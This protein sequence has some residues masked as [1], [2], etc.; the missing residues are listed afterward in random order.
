MLYKVVFLGYNQ[1]IANE[2][3]FAAATRQFRIKDVA[4]DRLLSTALP[5]R[6]RQAG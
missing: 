1:S 4:A 5:R 3:Q 6:S 2:N